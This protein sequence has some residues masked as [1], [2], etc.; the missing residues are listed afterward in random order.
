MPKATIVKKAASSVQRSA[1]KQGTKKMEEEENAYGISTISELPRRKTTM[2][3]ESFDGSTSKRSTSVLGQS[4]SNYQRGPLPNKGLTPG[5][6][7]SRKQSEESLGPAKS[8]T[9][10]S[11]FIM[12]ANISV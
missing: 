3:G 9:K 10:K 4:F 11:D 1:K 2:M 6:K 7:H 12:K 5:R 8:H